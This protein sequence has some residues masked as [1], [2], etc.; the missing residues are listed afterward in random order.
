MVSEIQTKA[1]DA[2]YLGIVGGKYYSHPSHTNRL[3]LF[4]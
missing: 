2:S 1:I 3:I 4:L